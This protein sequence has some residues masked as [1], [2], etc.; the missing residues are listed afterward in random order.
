MAKKKKK[1]NVR[2]VD[3]DIV[4]SGL[5]KKFGQGL[6]LFEMNSQNVQLL[7]VDS[8]PTNLLALDHALGIFG[9]PQGRL[10]EIYGQLSLR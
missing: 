4:V 3:W 7:S 8:I 10:I 9:F 6:S 5:G 1:E 2:G